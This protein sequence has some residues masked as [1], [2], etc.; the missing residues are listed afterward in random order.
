MNYTRHYETLVKNCKD[1]N[2]PLTVKERHHIVPKCLGGTDDPE[3]LVDMTP[4]EHFVAHQLLV[5]MHPDNRKLLHAINM[6]HVSSKKNTRNNKQYSWLRTR[7]LGKTAGENNPSAK[8]TNAEALEIYHSCEH[9]DDLAIKY[10]VSRANIIDIKRK[11]YYKS[12]TRDIKTLPGHHPEDTG[13]GK[14][15][16]IPFDMIP[17]IYMETGSY[18][19]FYDTYRATRAVVIGIKKRKKFKYL[20]SD[21]GDPGEIRRYN[22]TNSDL[23]FIH[24]SEMS[25]DELA[26][27]F[28]ISGSTVNNIRTGYTRGVFV[29]DF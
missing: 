4:S 20:T 11:K 9:M 7:Y 3:N 14:E 2:E 19:Y 1:R 5:K 22:L 29:E 25:D 28:G 8:F 18:G 21:L 27:K 13:K 6:M 23:T 26:D 15:F 24:D 12:V 10:G 16:P 17:L